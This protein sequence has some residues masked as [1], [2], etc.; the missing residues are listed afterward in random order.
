MFWP[1]STVAWSS[2]PMSG[3]TQTMTQY[4]VTDK[5]FRAIAKIGFH[6]LL[7]H[8]HFRGDE[9]IFSGIPNF[10]MNG[11]DITKYVTWPKKQILEDVKAGWVPVNY[12]HILIARATQKKI[13][14]Y[15]QFFLGPDMIPYVYK[16]HIANNP[17]KLDYSLFAGHQ[18]CL[19]SN[20]GR[21][22]MKDLGSIFT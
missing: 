9:E 18:F 21:G 10:I 12:C 3:A 7:K 16:I 15:V 6:Y 20:G 14:A 2:L 13:W 5:Y 11:G 1:L 8:L 22:T 17:T 19:D 4:E